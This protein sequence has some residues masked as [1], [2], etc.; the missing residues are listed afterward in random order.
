MSSSFNCALR[1]RVRHRFHHPSLAVI[2]LIGA[3]T[4]A[5]SGALAACTPFA[6]NNVTVTCS[7]V[8]FDQGP[9]LNIGYGDSGGTQPG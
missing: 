2:C 1:E 5:P 7:G 8:T 6:G 9:G 4:F 3:A